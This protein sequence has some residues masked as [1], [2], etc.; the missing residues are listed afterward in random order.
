MKKFILFLFLFLTPIS[1]FAQVEI[2]EIM[3]NPSQH[4]NYNEW[5]EIFNDGPSVSLENFT[6]CGKTLLSGYVDREGNTHMDSGLLLE[7]NSYAVITDGGS[8]TEVYDN[9]DVSGFALH[10][11]AASLCGGLT[12]SGKTISLEE[13]G[14]I[15]HEVTYYDDTSSGDSL[16]FY[17]GVWIGCSSTPGRSNSCVQDDE[18][19][20][21]EDEDDS[22]T[23][24]ETNE[25]EKP[26]EELE[27]EIVDSDIEIFDEVGDEK[28][29]EKEVVYPQKSIT[30]ESDNKS[31]KSGIGDEIT[32]DVIYSK[33]AGNI[34][35]GIFLLLLISISL[36]VI[37]IVFKR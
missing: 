8:G 37:F 4:D 29:P 30:Q 2:N 5:I 21:P 32:G 33:S 27:D 19:N 22:E 12:N 24:G 9:F 36:N 11:D 10:V 1:S 18:S 20:E 6:L 34:K 31:S 25:A 23:Q 14:G 28:V 7:T 16:Q 15:V 26:E 17:D 35:F 13:N 3:Y